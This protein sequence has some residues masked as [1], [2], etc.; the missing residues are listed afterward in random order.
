MLAENELRSLPLLMRTPVLLE[1]SSTNMIS[2]NF[3]YFPKRSHLQKQSHW[4]LG[5]SMYELGTGEGVGGS[6]DR[7]QL[8][9]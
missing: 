8:S 9:V 1:Q 3:N 7:T 5:A 4:W 2:F 6:R